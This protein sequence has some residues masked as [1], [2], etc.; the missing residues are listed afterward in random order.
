MQIKRTLVRSLGAAAATG[1]LFAQQVY[2]EVPASASTAI[3]EAGADA[4][5]IGGLVL[6][7]IIGIAAFKYLRRAL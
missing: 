4:A 6:V 2:A 5:T 3:T 1:V 7:V